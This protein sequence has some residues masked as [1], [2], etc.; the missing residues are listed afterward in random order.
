MFDHTRF[1]PR[2]MCGSWW[3]GW[4]QMAFV[5]DVV[6]AIAYIAIAVVLMYLI[7]RAVE[8]GVLLEIAKGSNTNSFTILSLFTLFAAFIFLC[9][10][11]HAID[12]MAYYRAFYHFMAIERALTAIISLA[13]F[14]TLYFGGRFIIRQYQVLTLL[15]ESAQRNCCSKRMSCQQERK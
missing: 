14:P 7:A 3:D 12:A 11:G 1:M 2:R 13:T 5:S 9:G 4:W 6:I 15:S 10:L 8:S